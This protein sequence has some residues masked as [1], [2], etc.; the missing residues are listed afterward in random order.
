M[1]VPMEPLA[2]NQLLQAVALRII[3]QYLERTGADGISTVSDARDLGEG[4]DIVCRVAGR[5]TRIKVKPDPYCGTDPAKVADRQLVFYRKQGT[6]YAFEAI[7]HHL[8]RQPG[9]IFNSD[10]ERL[11]YYFLGLGQTEDEVAALMGEEDDVLL[12]ELRVERD[13]LHVIPMAPLRDWFAAH[14]EQYTPRPVVVGDHSAW[15]RLIPRSVLQAEV[16]V[17]IVGPIFGFIT[18]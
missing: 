2:G 14:F 8:T 11:Y 18:R 5:S 3:T 10:A 7:S 1:G 6:D 4:T 9:W 17:D 15:Y 13:E 16:P 12:S